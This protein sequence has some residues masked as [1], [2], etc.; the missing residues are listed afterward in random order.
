MRIRQLIQRIAISMIAGVIGLAVL[1][2]AAMAELTT[3]INHDRVEIKLN[4]N[5]STVSVKGD[6]DAGQDLVIK[7]TG[8]DGEEKL[9]SKDKIGGLLWMNTEEHTFKDVP[10]L[11]FIRSTGELDNILNQQQ[12]NA[13][14][15]GYVA[16]AETGSIEPQAQGKERT[17]LFSEFFRY[18]ESRDLYDRSV[19][20]IDT[21]AN[22]DG[23]HYETM[24]DW[25]Y[26]AKPG[27]YDV[28]VYSVKDGRVTDTASGQV[29]VEETGIV[30]TLSDLATEKG[31][32]YGLLAIGVALTAGFGV[33]IIFGKGG[34]AH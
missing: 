22:A 26:Q 17:T 15:I 34:G 11:Y 9:K 23:Q 8:P 30:K 28:T 21:S 14:G 18:K 20:G 27:T 3:R 16:L 31:G 19:G 5:G 6:S 13:D 2:P 29:V 4:Y 25:P 1:A 32:F 7:I 24:F 12:L 10:T 33:G